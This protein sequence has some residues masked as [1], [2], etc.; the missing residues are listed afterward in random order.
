M[1]A[2]RLFFIVKHAWKILVYQL[3]NEKTRMAGFLLQLGLVGLVLADCQKL[4][5]LVSAKRVAVAVS[6]SD[7]LFHGDLIWAGSVAF[8]QAKTRRKQPRS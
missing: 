6:G 4:P 1:F 2:C 7:K 8:G 3:A 5:W